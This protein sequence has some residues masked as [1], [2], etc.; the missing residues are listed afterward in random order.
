MDTIDSEEISIDCVFGMEGSGEESHLAGEVE[1]KFNWEEAGC[2]ES[3]IL[4]E[5][6]ALF[7]D[8][9]DGPRS[10]SFDLEES[11]PEC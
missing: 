6:T 5:N 2:D 1:G 11:L 8:F 3:G 10:K 7:V 9:F 4:Y